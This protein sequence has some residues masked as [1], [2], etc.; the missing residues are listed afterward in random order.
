MTLP[1]VV[2]GDE[3][4]EG[5]PAGLLVDLDD[6]DVDA[7]REDRVGRLEEAGRLQA[8]LVAVT[9]RCRRTPRPAIWASVIVLSATPRALK[10]PAP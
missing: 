4:L 10:P 8:R 3:L 7:E 1:H 5:D 9:G 2:D 6:G